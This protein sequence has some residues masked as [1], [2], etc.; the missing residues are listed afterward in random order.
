[1]KK[2]SWGVKELDELTGGIQSILTL[3]FGETASGKTTLAAYIPITRITLELKQKLGEIPEEGKFIVIDGD[4]GFDSDRFKQI[5][6]TNGISYSEVLKHLIY[7]EVTEFD[8]QHNIVKELSGRIEKEGIKPLFIAF[9]PMTA[10]YRGIILRTDMKY[11][12]SVISTYTGKLDLQLSTLRHLSV[13]YD[14]PVIVTTWPSSPVGEAFGVKSE[15]PFIGGRQMGF[16]PKMILKLSIVREGYPEREAYLWKSKT[17]TSG[18][19]C[20]F[21]LSDKGIEELSEEEKEKLQKIQSSV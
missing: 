9:D 1:M 12:A 8:K 17:L 5:L 13:V 15:I 2:Y 14:I 3:I 6:E 20:Y 19:K 4:G 18:R 7:S 16:L 21:K 11:R 10:I